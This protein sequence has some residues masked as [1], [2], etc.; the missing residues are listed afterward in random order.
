MILSWPKKIREHSVALDL[1][2]KN[3]EHKG[4]PYSSKS[5]L[6]FRAETATG[7]VLLKKCS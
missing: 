4:I 3:H 7:G 6:K 5:L 1:S 2:K